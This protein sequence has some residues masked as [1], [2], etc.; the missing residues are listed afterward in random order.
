MN[1]TNT[2]V[3]KIIKHVTTCWLSLGK[4]LSR[5]VM[6][7]DALELYFL[8]EFENDDEKAKDNDKVTREVRLV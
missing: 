1:F 4:S 8:S 3:K 6:Q 5:T 7:W 2:Q